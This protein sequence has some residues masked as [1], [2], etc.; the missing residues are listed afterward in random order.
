MV[1]HEIKCAPWTIFSHLRNKVI[2]SDSEAEKSQHAQKYCVAYQRT[3]QCFFFFFAYSWHNIEF[4][5]F[6]ICQTLSWCMCLN[7]PPQFCS[8][9]VRVSVRTLSACEFLWKLCVCGR[10][11]TSNPALFLG[12]KCVEMV[13]TVD[14]EECFWELHLSGSAEIQGIDRRHR[15]QWN[16]PC[17]RLWKVTD[18]HICVSS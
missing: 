8:R 14:A 13:P 6:P 15:Q 7:E 3:L 2:S 18:E 16:G 4:T 10:P 17:L 9:A 11:A 5:A 12:V 1:W